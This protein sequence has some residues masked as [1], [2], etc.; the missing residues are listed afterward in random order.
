M[1]LHRAYLQPNH[2]A[3]GIF[4]DTGFE[5]LCAKA[6]LCSRFNKSSR[7]VT[8]A[9]KKIGN[10]LG[11]CSMAETTETGLE[12]IFERTLHTAWLACPFLAS[13]LTATWILFLHSLNPTIGAR[14]RAEPMSISTSPDRVDWMEDSTPIMLCM[15]PYHEIFLVK[16][17]LY[18]IN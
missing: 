5:G 9:Q 3:F 4:L 2:F 16:Y 12:N 7:T 17:R 18:A 15:V 8:V 6:Y 10:L 1:Q 13:A 11:S 14:M